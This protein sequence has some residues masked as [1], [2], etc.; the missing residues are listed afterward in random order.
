MPPR[1]SACLL[2][3]V[4]E[5][6]LSA[7][8]PLPLALVLMIF[9]LL[10]VDCRLRCAEVCR[11]WCAVLSEVSLW[12]RLDLSATSGGLARPLTDALLRAATAKARGALT[13]LDVSGSERSGAFPALLAVVTANAG[14]LRELRVYS[15]HTIA[16]YGGMIGPGGLAALLRA[17]P[18]L[19]LLAAD[20]QCLFLEDEADEDDEDDEDDEEDCTGQMLRNEGVFAPLRL[21]RV[22]ACTVRESEDHDWPVDAHVVA[23]FAADLAAHA[24]LQ[25]LQLEAFPLDAAGLDAV[26]SVALARRLSGVTFAQCALSAECAPALL[27]LL[28]GDALKKLG[29]TRDENVLLRGRPRARRLRLRCVR[30]SRSR[31]FRS[32]SLVFGTLARAGLR[33]WAR[34]RRTRACR[35][36]T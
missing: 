32:C 31:R 29:I 20:V 11:G 3:A 7:L 25:E 34:S 12:T 5:R 21:R 23:A 24:S 6:E 14:A 4:P 1:R 10:P 16:L 27:R 28:G 15:P 30:T 22:L 9:S 35:S 33:C 26:V 13:A 17:A 8:A 36:W 2:A 19:Q 18:Q